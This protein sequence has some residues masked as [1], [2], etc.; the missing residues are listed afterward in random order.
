MDLHR[1]CG[2]HSVVGVR[3]AAATLGHRSG[4]G[5]PT[6]VTHAL[7]KKNSIEDCCEVHV[8]R[9]VQC[10][11]L[12]RQDTRCQCGPLAAEWQS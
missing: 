2:H 6:S 5:V 1:A 4:P 11:A 9:D 7:I 8:G 12:S 10:F 3:G